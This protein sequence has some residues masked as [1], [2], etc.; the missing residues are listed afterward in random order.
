[1]S[2]VIAG[3][4]NVAWHFGHALINAGISVSQIYSRN[5]TRGGA[6]A[7]ELD[8]SY[9]S[10]PENLDTHADICILAV[11]D[12]AIAMLAKSAVF[13]EFSLVVHTAGTVPMH[14]LSGYT[15]HFGVL[16]PLQTLTYGKAVDFT[17]IPLLVESDTPESL[18]LLMD[19]AGKVSS[20]IHMVSSEDRLVFHLAGV[21]CSNFTNR[22]YALTEQYLNGKQMS[23][24][25]LKPLILETACKAVSMSP[26]KA[27][28]GPAVRKDMK[29]IDKHM[30]L[31]RNQPELL[32]IYSLFTESIL[33]SK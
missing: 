1:M 30:T 16:Y 25:L 26:F 20:R 22:L 4:G 6:L 31:L 13:K 28:T 10:L 33:R 27:Q 29:T 7:A 11:S 32:N 24:E 14:V 15:K 23:F 21:I 3:S 2:A 12:D 18:S 19:I 8:T 5:E 17:E 9:V